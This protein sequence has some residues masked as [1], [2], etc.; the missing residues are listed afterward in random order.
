MDGGQKVGIVQITELVARRIL[1]EA[2]VGD[3][4]AIGQQFGI[5]RFGSRV[6]LWIPLNARSCHAWPAHGCR[7]DSACR[8]WG[9]ASGASGSGSVMAAA[10]TKQRRFRSVSLFWLIPNIITVAGLISGLT[11]LGLLWMDDGQW[12][13]G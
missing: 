3:Q 6:D 2:G 11:A 4:L 13:L 12:S 9:N 5:I 10:Q 1:L 7:G 8:S